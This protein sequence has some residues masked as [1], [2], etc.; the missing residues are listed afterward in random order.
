[1][2]GFGKIGIVAG[3]IVGVIG[4]VIGQP[5]IGILG[6]VGALAAVFVATTK[7]TAQNRSA[8]GEDMVRPEQRAIIRPM[9]KLRDDIA[10]I[11]DT[12]KTSSAVRV[13]GG[14]AIAEADRILQHCVE[15]LNIQASIKRGY[16]GRD[17]SAELA[18]LQ[19]ELNSTDDIEH[20]TTLESTHQAMQ[21]EHASQSQMGHALE[22]IDNNLARA[23]AAL[24]EMKARLSV[25]ATTSQELG[26]DENLGD[27]ISRMKSLSASF[28]EAEE[29]LRVQSS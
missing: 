28:D 26:M 16:S 19:N 24:T 3:L 23:L 21:M 25:S 17:M 27:T 4:F 6:F 9:R 13:I 5:A 1:M 14:E 10:Q 12:N 22:Q 15:M 18:R 11:V 29:F 7:A 20:K 2:T 8:L